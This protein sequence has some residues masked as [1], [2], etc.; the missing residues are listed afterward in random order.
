ML[1]CDMEGIRAGSNN[2]GVEE[3]EGEAEHNFG[4]HCRKE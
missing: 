1:P 2:N 3:K 4:G